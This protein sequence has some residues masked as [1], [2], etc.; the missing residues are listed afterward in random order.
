MG[1]FQLKR[2]PK[3]RFSQRF[4]RMMLFWGLPMVCLELIGIPRDLWGAV[5]FIVLPLTL[6]AV[7][8]GTALEHWFITYKKKE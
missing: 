4:A 1:I 2:I 3:L 6:V 7:L 8:A 5:L